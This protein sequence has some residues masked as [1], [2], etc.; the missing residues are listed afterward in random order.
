MASHEGW[1]LN[2]YT[3][4]RTNSLFSSMHVNNDIISSISRAALLSPS[5]DVGREETS[6]RIKCPN[7]VQQLLFGNSKN[8]NRS[9]IT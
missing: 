2:T 4:S 8:M 9:P 7:V 5:D 6:Q 3:G 1:L